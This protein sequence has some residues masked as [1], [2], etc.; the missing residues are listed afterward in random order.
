MILIK[1]ILS[2]LPTIPAIHYGCYPI[3]P[4]KLVYVELYPAKHLYNNANQLF[5]MLKQFCKRPRDVR[6]TTVDIDTSKFS[7]DA[8]MD[9]FSIQLLL[10][11]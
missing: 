5:K 4:N 6:S 10:L 8:L 2:P 11:S 3:A 9:E 7:W 1:I